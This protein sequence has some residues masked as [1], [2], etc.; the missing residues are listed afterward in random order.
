MA[1][2]EGARPSG[3][4]LPTDSHPGD[5]PQ[6]PGREW[7]PRPRPAV[8]PLGQFIGIELYDRPL[9]IGWQCSFLTIDQRAL[10]PNLWHLSRCARASSHRAAAFARQVDLDLIGTKYARV[11][12]GMT[13]N[14][15]D[16]RETLLMDL[17]G[18]AI[19]EEAVT[20]GDPPVDQVHKARAL[21]TR[22][23]EPGRIFAVAQHEK[24]PS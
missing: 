2:L 13:F 4:A 9:G 5:A 16:G 20:A 24:H 10:E 8:E 11:A 19:G 3:F 17:I 21:A 6:S 14:G 22:S 7:R 15:Q 23:P 12:L 1:L 18:A